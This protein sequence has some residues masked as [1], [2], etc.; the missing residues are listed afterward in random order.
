MK[1]ALYVAVSLLLVG[2]NTLSGVLFALDTGVRSAKNISLV[3]YAGS[4]AMW[5][6]ITNLSGSDNTYMSATL[7]NAGDSTAYLR[8]TNFG[9]I[10]P[11]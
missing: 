1:K 6:G 9:A 5:T 11:L 10:L 2:T 4:D 8:A 7:V 3:P